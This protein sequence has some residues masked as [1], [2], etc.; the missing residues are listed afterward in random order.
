MIYTQK[1]QAASKRAVVSAAVRKEE[2]GKV[3]PGGE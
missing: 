3:G 1:E 2:T